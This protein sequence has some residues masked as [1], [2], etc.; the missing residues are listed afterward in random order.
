MSSP[1][2]RRSRKTEFAQL[3]HVHTVAGDNAY[4]CMSW[5]VDVANWKGVFHVVSTLVLIFWFYVFKIGTKKPVVGMT[6][7]RDLRYAANPF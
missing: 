7:T 5:R 6:G 3:C 1:R 4:R 2:L